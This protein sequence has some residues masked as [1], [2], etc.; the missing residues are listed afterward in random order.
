MMDSIQKIAT[1]TLHGIR[2]HGLRVE[3][4]CSGPW[5]LRPGLFTSRL[6]SRVW[7]G[8]WAVGIYHVDQVEFLRCAGWR[9]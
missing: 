2:S 1:R 9:Q 5:Q 8:W 3:F 7:W 4:E 6:Q